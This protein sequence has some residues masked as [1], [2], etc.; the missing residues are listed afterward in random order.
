[1]RQPAQKG[2][3]NIV[4]EFKRQKIAFPRSLETGFGCVKSPLS[5]RG[6]RNLTLTDG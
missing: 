4:P 5:P 1:M 3:F 2:E 6:R